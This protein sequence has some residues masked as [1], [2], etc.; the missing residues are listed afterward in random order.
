MEPLT[1]L[2][3]DGY[4]IWMSLRLRQSSRVLLGAFMGSGKTAV[5]L[6]AFAMRR[7][8]GTATVALVIAPLNVAKDTWPEEIE[9]WSFSRE[10]RY[11]VVVGTQEERLSALR[12]EAD[13]YI[14]NRE[15]VGW[16][17]EAVDDWGRFDTLIYDEASRLKAG[18]KR[19]LSG[20]TPE[21]R[22]RWSRTEFGFMTL[23]RQ[24]FTNIWE[25]SGTPSPN[26]LIDL[27]GPIYILDAGE[28]LGW[29]RPDFIKRWFQSSRYSYS[30]EPLPFAEEQIMSRL[31][32]IFFYLEETDYIQLP[33]LEVHDRWITLDS[34]VHKMYRRFEREMVLDEFDVEAVNNA[35]L[36]NKLLQFANGSVYAPEDDEGIVYDKKRPPVAKRV[37]DYK[38][39]ELESILQ[40][41]A[42]RPVLIAYSFKFDVHAIKK[43]FPWI[44]VYGES[45]SDYRDWNSGKLKAMLLHPASA[46]HGLNFQHGGHLAVW[47]GLNWSLELYQQFNKRLH[48]RGQK[49]TFV[50][51]Y[52]IL[53]RGT[54]DA[55]AAEVLHGKDVTQQSIAE[56]VRVHIEEIRQD[57]EGWTI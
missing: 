29:K 11:A 28:R 5:T 49:S 26:G 20:K 31:K 23:I 45:S 6:H 9:K 53:A 50:R 38:L 42:G 8:E 30:V 37:H 4:Q 15:N 24:Q 43:R 56:C 51:L 12:M 16:L 21:G 1:E 2:D 25:L 46:A 54:N 44:R 40:E 13:I 17:W 35:V 39:A 55:R 22:K 27:W 18:K 57:T 3:F 7:L 41:A 14:V 19:R 48:R 36:C 34:R 10:L 33:D 47:Y 52:R 32:D